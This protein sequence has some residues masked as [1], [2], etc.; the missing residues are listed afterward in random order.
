MGTAAADIVVKN[1]ETNSVAQS[2][3]PHE[4]WRP[5]I[6]LLDVHCLSDNKLPPS[7]RPESFYARREEQTTTDW[8]PS[9]G[10]PSAST[11]PCNRGKPCYPAMAAL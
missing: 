8:L 7:C 9:M 4:P 5:S 1:M 2:V 3:P 10:M 11:Q 6:F